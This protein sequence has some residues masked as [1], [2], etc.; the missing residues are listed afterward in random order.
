MNKKVNFK[1][2]LRITILITVVVGLVLLLLG[3]LLSSSSSEGIDWSDLFFNLGAFAILLIPVQIYFDKVIRDQLI[4]Q[5]LNVAISGSRVTHSGILD[6]HR[7]TKVINYD[8]LISNSENFIIG[9]HTDCRI[10]EDNFE[11]LS[12]RAINGKKTTVLLSEKD[13][14]AANF[15][16]QKIYRSIPIESEISLV[17]NKIKEIN[18]VRD[19]KEKI[20]TICHDT[21]LRYSFVYSDLGIWIKPYRNSVGTAITP[22]FYVTNNSQ[23]YKFYHK[24]IHEL[25][26]QES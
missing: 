11:K 24:D 18:R 4:E 13:G 17:V 7:N 16:Q 25:L 15:L 20:V 21:I 23:L 8:D 22:G 10:I 14:I 1:I 9:L 19:V 3:S 5:A 2:D 12:E 6:F 26:D